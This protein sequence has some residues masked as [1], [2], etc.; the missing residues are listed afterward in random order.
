MRIGEVARR[1]GVNIETLR[2]YE[3]RGLLAEPARG[4]NGHRDCHTTIS[5]ASPIM[6]E[7][8]GTTSSRLSCAHQAMSSSSPGGP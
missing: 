7:K 5:A 8:R 4:P 2:Y 1:A 3:R 6:R